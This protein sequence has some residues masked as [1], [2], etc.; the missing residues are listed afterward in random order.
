[1][2]VLLY[3]LLYV[4]LS[5]LFE[6]LLLQSSIE[7]KKKGSEC[8]CVCFLLSGLNVPWDQM[9][10]HLNNHANLSYYKQQVILSNL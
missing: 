2:S 6:I 7:K 5:E 4:F 1:M 8:M 9:R 3:V 10:N